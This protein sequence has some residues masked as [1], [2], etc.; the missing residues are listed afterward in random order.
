MA[1]FDLDTALT[2]RA[3][4]VYEAEIRDNWN[5]VIGPNGGYGPSTSTG[6]P[7]LQRRTSPMNFVLTK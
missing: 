3:Q 2:P 7:S 4:G 6:A 1:Q 5:V